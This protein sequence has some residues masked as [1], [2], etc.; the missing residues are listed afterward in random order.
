MVLAMPVPNPAAP[1]QSLLE[2][3]FVLDHE[4]IS[5]L[6]ELGLRHLWVAY[7][8]LE[9]ISNYCNPNLV[10]KYNIVASTVMP[11]FN[12]VEKNQPLRINQI[13][14]NN[15]IE[16]LIA[17]M[18][19]NDLSAIFI[20]ELIRTNNPLLDR[21][22][23]VSY[24]S[25]LMGMRLGWYVADQRW[26]IPIQFAIRLP[27]LAL[28]A[29]F[30]DIGMHRLPPAVCERFERTQIMTDPAWQRHI[31]F[32]YDMLE[33]QIDPSA[34][35]IALHHHQ[36]FDGSGFP[37]MPTY[38][39]TEE[40]R[41]G[42]QIHIFSRIVCAA[43]MFEM[44]RCRE[45]GRIVTTVNALKTIFQKPYIDWFD[46]IVLQ[47]L[48]QAVPAYVPGSLLEL[49][50]GRTA[51]VIEHQPK[52]PCR[53]QIQILTDFPN[54]GELTENE[55]ERIDL[56]ERDDLHIVWADGENVSDHYF[57][58]PD[59]D[60]DYVRRRSDLKLATSEKES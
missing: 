59:L 29:L 52:T 4:I 48:L 26:D 21:S 55:I 53:P 43:D 30:Y 3:G 19:T 8:S 57:E 39:G 9:H 24:I 46:P 11:T 2:V 42:E 32:G 41:K 60:V 45:Y 16:R 50:D 35:N 38:E 14:Y 23:R 36:H 40:P 12:A 10:E 20:E 58:P 7:Q 1:Q 13:A 51:A 18:L 34:R 31:R 54:T 56:T 6:N 5:R 25:L 49:N 37:L 47:A 44:F 27:N 33:D 28:G 22:L 15:A 17:E